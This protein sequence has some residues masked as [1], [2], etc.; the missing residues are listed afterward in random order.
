MVKATGPACNLRCSYCYYLEKSSLF[1]SGPYTMGSELLENFISQRIASSVNPSIHFEWHGGEPTLSGL[2]FFREITRLQRKHCRPGTRITNGLQTNGLKIDEEWACF[3]AAESFSVGLSLDG[4]AGLHDVFRTTADSRPTHSLVVE[5]FYR[6]KKHKVFCNILCVLHGK[7]AVEPDRVYGFFRDIGVNYLQFLP[8]VQTDGA[9]HGNESASP[10][11]IGDFLCRVFDLWIRG[12]VGRIVVQTFDEALRP[13]F[14]A[15]HALCIHR[16]TCGDVAVL[17][18]DGSFFACDHF[19]DPEHLI[20]NLHNRS[21]EDLSC[22]PRLVGF[23][24]AKRDTLPD[25]CLRCDVLSSCNGGCPKDRVSV[26]SSGIR[27]LNYLCP[28]Y[29][30]FFHHS[31]PQLMRLATHLKS[32]RP[33][34]EFKAD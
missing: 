10:D 3:L 33:Q 30:K 6:L 18:H 9:V 4:P 15:P 13:V 12:D 21:L 14:G 32:G 24:N 8:L 16:E 19:V 22:D 28:A 23:G 34:R 26:S 7:N 20:G 2:Q 29:K 27:N 31:N 25:E 5:A 1:P 11:E 17:E